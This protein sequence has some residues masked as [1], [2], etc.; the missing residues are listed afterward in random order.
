VLL[1]DLESTG[2]VILSG[3]LYHTQAN[4]RLRRVPIFNFDAEETL[5]SM[6]KIEQQ[7]VGAGAKLWIEHDKNFADSLKK[8]PHYYD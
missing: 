7:Y 4:R 2:P 8:A 6:Q 3:D 5:K 1:V